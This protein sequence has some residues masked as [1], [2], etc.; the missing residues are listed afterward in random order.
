MVGDRADEGIVIGADGVLARVEEDVVPLQGLGHIQPEG[1][2]TIDTLHDPEGEVG[3]GADM[4]LGR[5]WRFGFGPGQGRARAFGPPMRACV[6][7]DGHGRPVGDGVMCADDDAMAADGRQ[8]QMGLRGAGE[9]GSERSCGQNDQVGLPVAVGRAGANNPFPLG[10]QGQNL[11]LEMEVDIVAPGRPLESEQDLMG[12]HPSIPLAKGGCQGLGREVGKAAVEL[13]AFQILDILQAVRVLERDPLPL[14]G[15]GGLVAGDE[16]VALLVKVDGV[17]GQVE[18]FLKGLVEAQTLL[19]ERD[20]GRVGELGA[21]GLEGGRGGEGPQRAFPLQQVNLETGLAEEVGAGDANDAAADDED[22]GHRGNHTG[23]SG[24][25]QDGTSGGGRI[26]LLVGANQ[27]NH[28]ASPT[29]LVQSPSGA[30]CTG[31]GFYVN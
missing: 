29:K 15:R 11:G 10:Y 5:G 6:L 17:A 7:I 13:L 30:I 4:A 3:V 22:A 9:L 8:G 26:D 2:E 27:W 14:T 12:R 1:V 23:L 18:L 24:K 21:D 31:L 16:E 25:G 20:V 28:H 19:H